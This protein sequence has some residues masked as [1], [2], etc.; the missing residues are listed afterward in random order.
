MTIILI[1]DCN[2]Q[3]VV[4]HEQ[5]VKVLLGEIELLDYF[6]PCTICG[7]VVLRSQAETTD[8]IDY[9]CKPGCPVK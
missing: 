6:S 2:Q 8:K 4:Q 3:E 5:A 1:D 9:K 7:S